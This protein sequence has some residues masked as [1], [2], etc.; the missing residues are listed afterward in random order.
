MPKSVFRVGAIYLSAKRAD[1]KQIIMSQI[2]VMKIENGNA[3]G[4]SAQGQCIRTITNNAVSA[5]I[6]GDIIAVTKTN[7][8]VEMYDANRFNLI[9]TV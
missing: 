2:V 1:V 5:V 9:R 7:G 8:R 4:Y 6:N 3:V